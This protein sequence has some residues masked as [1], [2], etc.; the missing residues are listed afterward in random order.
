MNI[1]SK[2]LPLLAVLS[3]MSFNVLFN[4][5]KRVAKEVQDVFEKEAISY[6]KVE[7]PDDLNS[8]L[9]SK[10]T[11]DNFFQINAE[12]KLLG[13][14]YIDKAPSKTAQFDYLVITDP[15]YRILRAKVMVYRE[16]YGG[17]IGS[18][19][20]LKQFIGKTPNDNM[21]DVAAI[22]GATIS[23]KSMKTAVQNFLQSMEILHN[24]HIL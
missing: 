21:Q 8:Q 10:I 17:E 24:H 9:P 12:G 1:N 19:R 13:Y 20:W 15:H 23:V 11:A 6:S 16:E 5:G 14:A 7:V 18:R 2:L 3:L 22:S 4:P